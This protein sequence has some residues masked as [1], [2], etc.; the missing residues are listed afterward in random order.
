[1]NRE[2]VSV[3]IMQNNAALIQRFDVAELYLFGSVARNQGTDRSDLDFL[4]DFQGPATVDRVLNL[5]DY[6]EE[7][8]ETKVD[9]ITRPALKPSLSAK[10]T[11]EM[12]RV[13]V[14]RYRC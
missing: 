5:A 2:D 3:K 13:C 11:A 12:V 14:N 6:L 4:V 10:I 1:M 7:L 8:F 9:L